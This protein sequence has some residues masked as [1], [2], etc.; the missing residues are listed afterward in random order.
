VSRVRQSAAKKLLPS[1]LLSAGIGVVAGAASALLIASLNWAGTV[2]E[3]HRWLLTLL[4]LSGFAV[5]WVYWRYGGRATEG[6]NLLLE[7]IHD[8]Q[9]TVPLRMAPLVLLGTILTHLFGGSAGREGT[10]VQMGASLAEWLAELFTE[11]KMRRSVLMAG[12]AGGFG[13]VFGTPWAGAVFG[14]EVLAVGWVGWSSVVEGIGPCL[15]ASF[16]GDLT[17]RLIGV[18]H[19]QYPVG[20]QPSLQPMNW[21]WAALAG[22]VFG[23]IARIF[24][25]LEHGLTAWFKRAFTYP[26][27][28]PLVGGVL[29]A[30]LIWG[31]H[32][33]QFAGL[34]IPG[35]V[36]S[37]ST[38][39]PWWVWAAK[40]GLT[41]LTLGAG[42]KGGEV[43]PLFFIGAAA[44]SAMAPVISLSTGVLAAIGFAAVFAA[45][46]NTPITGLIMAMEL[47]GPR[48]GLL[49]GAAC[50]VAYLCSGPVGIY[51]SQQ[52]MEM[53]L[54]FRVEK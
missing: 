15:I 33:W 45:A 54:K 26:P 2:R 44:G 38:Q 50:A 30:L 23:L 27:L 16:A 24:S 40:L 7:E 22:A 35:I 51:S 1:I 6:N 18:H 13:G 8:P 32:A 41:A 48:T 47:F 5:G 52:P 14:V 4:P 34:G 53:R 17:V 12:I 11:H 19:T 25:T 49:A 43:T 31:L 42:F 37:F 36:A 28:R 20:V 39:Q 9:E 21:V 29:V 10:A 3:H 46:A